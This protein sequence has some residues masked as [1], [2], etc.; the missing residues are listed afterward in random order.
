MISAVRQDIVKR[1]FGADVKVFGLC[2]SMALFSNFD[3]QGGAAIRFH[4]GLPIRYKL[5]PFGVANKVQTFF[6]F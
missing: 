2:V 5:R 1:F 4:E 6:K 3:L